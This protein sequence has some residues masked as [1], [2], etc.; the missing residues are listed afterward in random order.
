[1]EYGNYSGAELKTSKNLTRIKPDAK[2]I[3][4]Y[5]DATIAFPL[6]ALYVLATQKPRKHKK[7]YKKMNSFYSSLS[8]K[9]EKNEL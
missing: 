6:I 8:K 7:L 4:V 3:S 5:C 2:T 1:M 9:F